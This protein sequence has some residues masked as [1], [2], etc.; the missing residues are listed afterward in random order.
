[1]LFKIFN[2]LCFKQDQKQ[3]KEVRLYLS[4]RTM[5]TITD[6]KKHIRKILRKY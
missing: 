3:T 5:Q 2:L 1:M 4:I 6:F